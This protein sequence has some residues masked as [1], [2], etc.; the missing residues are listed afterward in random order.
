VVGS[1]DDNL[2]KM[3]IDVFADDSELLQTA[4]SDVFETIQRDLGVLEEEK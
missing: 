4:A 3:R 2:S 1:K